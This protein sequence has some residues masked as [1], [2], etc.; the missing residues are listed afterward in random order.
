ALEASTQ[1]TYRIARFN[2]SALEAFSNRDS[3]VTF[4]SPAAPPQVPG[5][6]SAEKISPVTILLSWTDNSDTE[7][8]FRIERRSGGEF[9]VIGTAGVNDTEFMDEG[10]T[11]GGAYTYRIRAFNTA[12]SSGYS[13]EV[14][15]LTEFKGG[16]FV[17]QGGIVSIEAEHG[18]M[19]DY[20]EIK[21]A[22]SASGGAYIEIGSDKHTT[23]DLPECDDPLCIVTY[24]FRVSLMGIYRLWFRTLSEGGEDDS[25]F[26]RIGIG[27]WV[28]E[29]GRAFPGSW[30]ETQNSQLENLSFGTNILEVAYREDGTQIDKFMIQLEGMELPVGN[31]SPE[32]VYISPAPPDKPY[33]LDASLTDPDEIFLAW[34]H[35]SEDVTGFKVK[36]MEA[37]AFSEITRTGPLVRE[38]TDSGLE[39][40]TLYTYTVQAY[41]AAGN[42]NF[43]TPASAVTGSINGTGDGFSRQTSTRNYPNPFSER[44]WFHY[45]LSERSE[46]KLNVYNFLGQKVKQLVNSIQEPGSYSDSWDGTDQEGRRVSRGLYYC[47]LQHGS[48]SHVFKVLYTGTNSGI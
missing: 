39:G 36:R 9:E 23:E 38:Y 6:L 15:I 40:S 19:G 44:T 22:Q 14:E 33:Q 8:G 4:D 45:T 13:N 24:Y 28:R 41:N 48:S 20:W 25:F 21:S 43:A 37:D 18:Q 17:E 31:G 1:Y 12:G 10:V 46:V 5:D 27:D 29:N 32:S 11:E 42:S 3:T 7:E 34:A 35:D 30:F 16:I 26:W 2:A 47:R